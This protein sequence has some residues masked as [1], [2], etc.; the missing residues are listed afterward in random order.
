MNFLAHLYLSGNS[1]GIKIGNFIGDAIK[2]SDYNKYENNIRK[3]ILLHRKIDYFTDKHSVFKKSKFRLNG[4]YKKHSGIVI[5]IFYDHFLS[6]NWEKYSNQSLNSFVKESY[7]LLLNNYSVLP[8]KVKF[9]LPFM[10]KNNW[11][12]LYSEING[13]E[14]VLNGMSK[15]TSLPQHT[16]FAINTLN[17]HYNDFQNEFCMFFSDIKTYILNIDN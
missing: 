17:N 1:D 8:Q 12:E 13:I 3:G 5:D 7:N 2:G 16:E 14:R 4:K 6:V 11:L 9:F 10:I 15:K